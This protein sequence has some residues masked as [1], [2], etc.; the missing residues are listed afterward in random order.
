MSGIDGME[1]PGGRK[2]VGMPVPGADRKTFPTRSPC[3]RAFP[4]TARLPLEAEMIL[5]NV[6]EIPPD[7]KAM[8]QQARRVRIRIPD[9]RILQ[10]TRSAHR[11][12]PAKANGLA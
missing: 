7:V 10:A 4:R 3:H 9:V 2:R 6:I 5:L 12:A 11:A 1:V 8:L